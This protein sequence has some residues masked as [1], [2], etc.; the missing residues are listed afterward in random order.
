MVVDDECMAMIKAATSG[1][2]RYLTAANIMAASQSAE[3]C[4][5]YYQAGLVSECLD[6]QGRSILRDRK[7]VSSNSGG[8]S[9]RPQERP[10]LF[11]KCD[12][13][14]AANK[15]TFRAKS[16]RDRDAAK[17]QCMASLGF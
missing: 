7:T 1:D 3:T 8:T 16:S 17:A 13:D 10:V 6:K 9:L 2:N 15:V 5:A 14:K 11:S 4:R 12:Y